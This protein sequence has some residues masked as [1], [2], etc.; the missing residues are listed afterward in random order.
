MS[1]WVVID[2][3]HGGRFLC[4]RCS[5]A[6]SL[7]LPVEISEYAAAAHAFSDRHSQCIEGE[8]FDQERWEARVAARKRAE[9]AS[10]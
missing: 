8:P 4:Q 2:M 7:Q 10:K 6:L 3:R 5:A 1:A 9:R